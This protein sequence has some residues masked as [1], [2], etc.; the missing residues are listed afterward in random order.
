MKMMLTGLSPLQAQG[1]L[2]CK[3]VTFRRQMM[4]RLKPRLHPCHPH[5]EK[6]YNNLTK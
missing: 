3:P 4:G 2:A 6:L 5:F 1:R